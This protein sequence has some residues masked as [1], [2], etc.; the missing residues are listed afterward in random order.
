ML[1]ALQLN[2]EISAECVKLGV[3]VFFQLSD[4]SEYQQILNAFFFFFQFCINT[5]VMKCYQMKYDCWSHEGISMSYEWGIKAFVMAK[6]LLLILC[7]HSKYC[8]YYL[9]LNL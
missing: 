2:V 7:T 3:L 8:I 9:G 5:P 6:V 4:I 1:G